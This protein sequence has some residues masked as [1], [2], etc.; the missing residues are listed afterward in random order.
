MD[1]DSV[2]T[3]ARQYAAQGQFQ[4]SLD[5]L[6]L[7]HDKSYEYDESL[8][9]VRRGS[10]LDDWLDLASRYPPALDALIAV[11]D[12]K[13]QAIRTGSG[14]P[15]LFMDVAAINEKLHQHKAT[16]ELFLWLHRVQSPLA[17]RCFLEAEESLIV[18]REYEIVIEYIPD[19]V[20]YYNSI[21]S[22]YRAMLQ[23][24]TGTTSSRSSSLLDSIHQVFARRIS[25]LLQTLHGVGRTEEAHRLRVLALSQC[26]SD[27]VRAAIPE[28]TSSENSE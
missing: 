17:S 16:A 18:T 9:I 25:G 3:T 27:I 7:F 10:A 8:S 23:R 6:Q 21:A 19:P 1:W 20:T 13:T 2:L 24:A 14:S 28:P 11:R 5:L 4:E 15:N 26:D 12:R 22:S